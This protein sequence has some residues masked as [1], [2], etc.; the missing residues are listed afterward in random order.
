MLITRNSGKRF[1]RYRGGRLAFLHVNFAC[2]K[3]GFL[4]ETRC[5]IARTHC[6]SPCPI[7][8][9]SPARWKARR[10]GGDAYRR[11]HPGSVDRRPQRAF[12]SGVS[13]PKSALYRVFVLK[14]WSFTRKGEGSS[15]SRAPESC[16]DALQRNHRRAHPRCRVRPSCCARSKDSRHRRRGVHPAISAIPTRP[17]RCSIHGRTRDRR[18][19]RHQRPHHRGRADHRARHREPRARSRPRGYRRGAHP[20]AKPWQMVRARA[21]GLRAGGYSACR[22]VSSGLDAVNEILKEIDTPVIFITAFPERLLTG[23]EAGACL[24]RH[25]AVPSRNGEGDDQSG[26]VFRSQGRPQNGL[27]RESAR[28]TGARC[29]SSATTPRNVS[30][31]N[32]LGKVRADANSP[33]TRP[34]AWPVANAKGMSIAR[35]WRAT[36]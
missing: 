25:Q 31:L 2:G 22:R 10:A 36:S 19:G 11:R 18:T 12:P 35:N 23:R 6:P 24:P 4:Q 13:A 27:N 28:Q 29:T 32:G 14:L 17:P 3:R 8:A 34:G 21:P 7:C 30:K 1:P 26:A 5:H 9:G 15:R 33:P 20:Q 16:T